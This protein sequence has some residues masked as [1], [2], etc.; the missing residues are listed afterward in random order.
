MSQTPASRKSSGKAF[1]H[2]TMNKARCAPRMPTRMDCMRACY[3]WA[4]HDPSA[5]PPH[6]AVLDRFLLADAV[7]LQRHGDV[8]R[9]SR[10]Y[11]CDANRPFPDGVVEGEGNFQRELGTVRYQIRR[12]CAVS[13][14]IG[15]D[16]VH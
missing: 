2:L 7:L 9:G 12:V 5:R 11:I 4:A 3:P 8:G 6:R 15:L 1:R 10:G 14:A 13:Y 16:H